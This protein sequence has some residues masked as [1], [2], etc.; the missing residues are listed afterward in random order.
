M[1]IPE[2]FFFVPSGCRMLLD[3]LREDAHVDADQPD[4]LVIPEYSRD[5]APPPFLRTRA[6][7]VWEE[8]DVLLSVPKGN[9]RFS[10][11][12]TPRMTTWTFL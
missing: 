6:G 12:S 4:A 2:F 1:E 8:A 7:E 9:E 5:R 3:A 10:S 11:C